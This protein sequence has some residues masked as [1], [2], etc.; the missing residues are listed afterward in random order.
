MASQKLKNIAKLTFR[1]M[2]D[3][4]WYVVQSQHSVAQDPFSI[5]SILK[6]ENL[7][8]KGGNQFERIEKRRYVFILLISVWSA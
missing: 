5:C 2:A 6:N 3:V 8:C 4:W 1:I 7:E